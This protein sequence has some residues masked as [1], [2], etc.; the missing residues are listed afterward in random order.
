MYINPAVFNTYGTVML[1]CK[2]TGVSK[3]IELP[4]KVGKVTLQL[5]LSTRRKQGTKI[6]PPKSLIEKKGPFLRN[7]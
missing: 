4:L 6:S 5:L 3:E 7:L 2:W 1:N